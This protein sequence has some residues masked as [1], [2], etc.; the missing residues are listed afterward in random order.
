MDGK[1]LNNDAILV[2]GGV[3]N[4]VSDFGILLTPLVL[5]SRLQMPRA[6][7]IGVSAV[8]TTG[9]LHVSDSFRLRW[10][11]LTSTALVLRA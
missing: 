2:S 1:C 10:S 8:F 11:K 4:V 3:I 5:I 6:K 9:F 7:K